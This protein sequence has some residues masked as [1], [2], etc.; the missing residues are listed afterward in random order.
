MAR[1]VIPG[2][3]EARAV[4]GKTEGYFEKQR[5]EFDADVDAIRRAL[6][7]QLGNGTDIGELIFYA[8]T[9]AQKQVA[10]G[11]N[12]LDNRPGSWESASLD[13][14]MDNVLLGLKND[15]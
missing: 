6:L 9:E 1:K 7:R 8:F 4:N 10:E 3:F 12:L 11:F 2:G 14:M 13:T 15:P 5:K